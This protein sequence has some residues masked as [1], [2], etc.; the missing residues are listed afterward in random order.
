[1]TTILKCEL[2]DYLEVACLYHYRVSL[3]LKSG[4]EYLGVPQ[5]TTTKDKQEFLVFRC[6]N[7]EV[8]DVELLNLKSMH[9]LTPHAQFTDVKFS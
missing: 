5:T 9:V 6:D 7:G 2:H 8:V 3:I 1:M 4:G